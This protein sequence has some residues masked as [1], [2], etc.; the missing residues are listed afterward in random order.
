MSYS[1]AS[2]TGLMNVSGLYWDE[3]LLGL[4]PDEVRTMSVSRVA[5]R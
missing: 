5:T 2:W 4:L 1:E 3:V